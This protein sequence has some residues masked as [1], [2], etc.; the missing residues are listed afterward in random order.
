MSLVG[1]VLSQYCPTQAHSRAER[2]TQVIANAA[3]VSAQGGYATQGGNGENCMKMD[4]HGY[5]EVRHSSFSI[6][7]VV[8]KQFLKIKSDCSC[9]F[10]PKEDNPDEV[11]GSERGLMLQQLHPTA[12]EA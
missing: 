9:L 12:G 1:R 2:L 11:L 7:I 10:V 4:E 6:Y 5:E 3:E 8:R